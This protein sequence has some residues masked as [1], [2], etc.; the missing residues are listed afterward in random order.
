MAYPVCGATTGAA[1][2]RAR[3]ART[4]AQTT[5]RSGDEQVTA[6]VLLAKALLLDL[7]GV[8]VD[9][10]RAVE[11]AWTVWAHDRGVDADAVLVQAHGRRAT[12]TISATAPHLDTATEARYVEDIEIE[13][14]DLVSVF[15]G[16]AALLDRLHDRRWAIVTSGTRRLATSRLT[17]F[18]LREPAVFVT[19]DDVA[20]GK[21]SPEPYLRAAREL[22]VDPADCIV[23]EDAPA[24]VQAA[25]AAGMRMI[26]VTT[27]HA[28]DS[29]GDATVVVGDIG[30]LR[31]D[32]DGGGMLR[33]EPCERLDT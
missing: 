32:V 24:G 6:D 11:H 12:D 16:V 3:F 22:G 28:R 30:S 18:G 17:M 2:R 7:D 33:I 9:S 13:A 25:R 20:Q 10:A 4:R 29:F 1:S 14:R 31:I 27:T 21:P 19:A 8:L 5:V 26:A 23:V 15:D